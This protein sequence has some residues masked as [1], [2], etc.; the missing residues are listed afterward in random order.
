LEWMSEESSY[1]VELCSQ[2]SRRWLQPFSASLD[3][4]FRS[5]TVRLTGNMR[6]ESFGDDQVLR[7]W[8][9]GVN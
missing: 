5:S 9:G 6:K 8:C 4:I 1:V 2:G 3:Y 7:R